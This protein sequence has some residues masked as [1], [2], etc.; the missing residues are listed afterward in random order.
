M[1]KGFNM[2]GDL[3]KF[4]SLWPSEPWDTKDWEDAYLLCVELLGIWSEWKEVV[5]GLLE[6]K[7]M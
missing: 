5:E 4:V 1:L 7:P 3:T 2:E 6:G